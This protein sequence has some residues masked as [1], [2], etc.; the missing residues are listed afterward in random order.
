MTKTKWKPKVELVYSLKN[1]QRISIFSCNRCARKYG[2]GGAKG[3]RFLKGLLKEMCKEVVFTA[4]VN[5]SCNEDATKQALKKGKAAISRSDTLVVISCGSGITATNL[6]NPGI[7]VIGA[8]D[9]MGI[10]VSTHQNNIIANSICKGCGHCVITYTGGICPL[11]KCPKRKK[12]EPC[13]KAPK[14]SIQ[15]TQ[16]PDQDCIWIEIAQVGDIAVLKDLHKMH[17]CLPQGE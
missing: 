16:N 9:T 15:C 11:S 13:S 3:I 2:T 12:Y 8:L 1:A 10:G 17:D 7:P 6:C 4:L 14:S 5:G